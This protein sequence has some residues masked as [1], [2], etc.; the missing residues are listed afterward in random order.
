MADDGADALA[1]LEESGPAPGGAVEAG[2]PSSAV[3][4]VRRWLADAG[5]ARGGWMS[6]PAAALCRAFLQ[7]AEASGWGIEVKPPEMGRLL[8]RL[9][10][11]PLRRAAS[12][13]LVSRESAEAL[14]RHAPGQKRKVKRGIQLLPGKRHVEA[15][16]SH[17]RYSKRAVRTCDGTEWE[18]VALLARVL[19]VSRAAVCRAIDGRHCVGG[20]HVAYLGPPVRKS[21][22]ADG[23]GTVAAHEDDFGIPSPS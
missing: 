21:R 16:R 14:W 4:A 10:F 23:S 5:V 18:S 20:M 3:E 1:R 19:G 12:G 9:G 15:V 11:K 6:P 7:H 2:E 22:K 17:G 13:F 8:L